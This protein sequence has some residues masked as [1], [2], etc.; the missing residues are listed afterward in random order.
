MPEIAS[1]E[2][3]FTVNGKTYKVDVAFGCWQLKVREKSKVNPNRRLWRDVASGFLVETSPGQSDGTIVVRET[4]R[5]R[6]F[7]STMEW[8]VES[9]V[10]EIIQ[11]WRAAKAER[12]HRRKYGY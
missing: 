6:L 3:Q 7:P 5:P 8:Q 10:K 9:S 4:R 11:T 2:R 12:E 1:R